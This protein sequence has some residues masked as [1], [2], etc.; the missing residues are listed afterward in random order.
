MSNPPGPP[1]FATEYNNDFDAELSMNE[2][3]V[4]WLLVGST[5]V[6]ELLTG[7]FYLLMLAIGLVAGALG[8]HFGLDTSSQLTLAA[9]FGGGSVVI[10]RGYKRR[11][12]ALISDASTELK[13]DVGEHVQVDFWRT[14]GTTEVKYRGAAWS[15]STAPGTAVTTGT[16]RIVEVA[17]NRL[18]IEKLQSS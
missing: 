14:D 16:H 13:L 11:P 3:T 7:T 5:V 8:A 6:L 1:A 15:A 4:W 2:P 18:I 9:L 17:G 10:G 12:S